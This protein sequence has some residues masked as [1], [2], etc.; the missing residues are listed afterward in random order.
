M[1]GINLNTGLCI[2]NSRQVFSKTEC[3]FNFEKLC[4][5]RKYKSAY[6]YYQKYNN[7]IDITDNLFK[8][9]C[10]KVINFE[11]GERD[12]IMTLYFIRY[13]VYWKPELKPRFK[14]YL[15]QIN[16]F[17]LKKLLMMKTLT[18]KNIGKCKCNNFDDNNI[19]LSCGHK[20]CTNCFIDQFQ[21]ENRCYKCD[22]NFY[23]EHSYIRT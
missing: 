23:I 20:C 1:T 4:L 22:K 17:Q 16:S 19:V 15:T 11:Y 2:L 18:V 7:F 12:H 13:M 14:T 8:N 10:L 3:T 21:N 6:F 9:M 5:N